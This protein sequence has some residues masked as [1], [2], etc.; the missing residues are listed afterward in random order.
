MSKPV[1][2]FELQGL[3]WMK[4]LAIQSTFALGGIFRSAVNFDPFA[5]MGYFQSTNMPT[6]LDTTTITTQIK[7]FVSQIDGYVY[8]LGDKSGAGAK[9]F[10]RIAL[11]DNS[12]TDYSTAIDQ[13][14]STSF[15]HGGLTIFGGVGESQRLVY[16]QDGSMRSNTITP[17]TDTNILSD[18]GTSSSAMST[19]FCVGSDLALYFTQGINCAVGKIVTVLGTSNNVKNTF[20]L[21]SKINARSITSDGYYLIIIGDENTNKNVHINS[22]CKVYFWDKVKSTADVIYDIPDTYLIGGRFVNG[23]VK[24]LGYSG[25]WE[26]NLHTP[27]KLIYP[28]SDKTILPT[29]IN[30]IGVQGDLLVWTGQGISKPIYAYGSLIGK[31]ILYNPFSY[32]INSTSNSGLGIIGDKFLMATTDP[33]VFLFDTTTDRAGATVVTTPQPLGQPFQFAYAKVVLE[34]PLVAINDQINLGLFDS[35]GRS[36]MDL[37]TRV[38]LREGAKK[39]LIF[40]PTTGIIT[41]FEDLVVEAVV[42]GNTAIKRVTVY[43]FPIGDDSQTL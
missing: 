10:Y 14:G 22:Q 18:S 8:A 16:E 42:S 6:I 43:G 36:I 24:I 4:G 29:D 5:K 31:P 30:Q 17:G 3:D 41:K 34:S 40:L 23:S 35:G 11:A 15:G 2:I 38:Y 39:D 9:C 33:K 19:D 21:Q 1:K 28:I 12:V 7:H 26:C 13:N 32:S 27:P 37:T 25:I 20:A